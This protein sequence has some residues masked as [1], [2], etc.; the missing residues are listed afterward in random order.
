MDEENK[1]DE[2]KKEEIDKEIIEKLPEQA[3]K[4]I[5]RNIDY[6]TLQNEI[7]NDLKTNPKYK[8]FFEMYN[9]SSID[10]FISHYK[11][12]KASWLTYGEMYKNK[13]DNWDLYYRNL[14]MQKLWEIQQKKLFDLQC[15]WRAEKVNL[16]EIEV[17]IDFR[18][19]EC[20]IDE[21]NFIEPITED[22]VEL[23]KQY[24]KSPDFEKDRMWMLSTWQDYDDF[25]RQYQREEEDGV[26]SL[27]EWYMF[28][29]SRKGTG[30]MLTLPDIRGEK[31]MV[32]H[33]I[34]A[35]EFHRKIAEK[36]QQQIADGT[37]IE[38]PK[39]DPRPHFSYY[40]EGGMKSFIQKFEDKKIMDY[41][42]AMEKN[43]ELREDRELEDAIETLKR[44]EED[45]PIDGYFNWREAV[46]KT[47]NQYEQEK[48]F[49]E[50]DSAYEEYLSRINLGI[51]HEPATEKSRRWADGEWLEGEKKRLIEARILNGEPG[52][53]NF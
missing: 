33:K 46:I 13:K 47:A 12:K 49:D 48:V 43:R 40:E 11:H 1:K 34:W 16:P 3:K 15:L 36:K 37:Y 30:V 25:K 32:Y 2:N 50:M 27:P 6:G 4:D 9:P 18:Y 35:A 52:D 5:Q 17:C 41:Y 21:C 10:G 44:A 29:D 45:V 51:A 42:I 20:R 14:A 19:W 24:L 23:Y 38:P 8:E 53:F 31:E 28:Y 39:P 22:E 26:L 7:E